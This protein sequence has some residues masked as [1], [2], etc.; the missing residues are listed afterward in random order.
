MHKQTYQ[1]PIE[2]LFMNSL[3]FPVRDAAKKLLKYYMLDQLIRMRLDKVH[4][5][6]AKEFN[7]SPQQWA[8]TLDNVILTKLTYFT[9]HPKLPKPY[10]KKL[11]KIAAF[12]SGKPNASINEVIEQLNPEA[13]IMNDW[14]N[15]VKTAL[16]KGK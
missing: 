15:N 6:L 11:V 3:P 10:L 1:E 13:V 14:L 7:L 16:N 4:P 12:A 8:L 9:I 2:I 5:D